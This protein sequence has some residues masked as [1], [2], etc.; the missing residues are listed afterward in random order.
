MQTTAD[1]FFYIF[2]AVTV[3]SAGVVVFSR[4]LLY[5]AF[6][7]LF[8]LS[9][10]AALYALLGADFLAVTQVLVYVGGILVLI[11]FG[12]MFTQKVYDVR[13]EAMSFKRARAA[14]IG[15]IVF[16]SLMGV[17]RSVP[18]PQAVRQ[19]QPTSAAIGDLLLSEYLLP[20]EA[21]SV[22]LLVVLI[23]AVLVGKKEVEEE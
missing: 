18:W 1:F 8:T 12:I 7:L 4:N 22:L 6:A 14:V 15:V 16:V 17:V 13:A 9:G 10:V 3:L 11:L 23:G 5:S 2:A 21:I 19:P 20:F